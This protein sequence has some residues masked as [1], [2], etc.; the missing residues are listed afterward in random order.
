MSASIPVSV[1]AF[2]TLQDDIDFVLA[3]H[4]TTRDDEITALATMVGMLGKAQSWGVDFVSAMKN[5]KAP[6]C[7][8]VDADTISVSAGVVW[9]ANGAQSFRLPRRNTSPVTVEASN[10][11]IGSMAVGWHYIYAV[12]DSAA[13]TFTVKISAS[14]TA[15]TGLTN[16][17]LIGWFYN[18]TSSVL[19]IT[20]GI[21]GNVKGGNRDVPNV[22][23]LEGS[24]D[25]S[26]TSTSHAD[27]DNMNCK[28]YTSGRPVIITLVMP[29][30]LNNGS[31]EIILDIDG[32]TKKTMAGT[33]GGGSY[34]LPL[35]LVYAEALSAGTHTIKATWKSDGT[36]VQQLGTSYKRSLLVMEA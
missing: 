26:T 1:P 18:E 10:L 34:K 30:T 31:G 19:D 12:A 25:I 36:S 24:T 22:V 23:H 3:Q 33:Q 35:T 29:L 6:L 14:P 17:E 11:D 15:P 8:K 2:T 5:A 27:V 7:T 28:F 13:T 16:F 20:S 9:I 32:S 4:H 21:V